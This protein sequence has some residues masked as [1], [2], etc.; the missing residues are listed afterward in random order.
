MRLW[1]A[2]RAVSGVIGWL[3]FVWATCGAIGVYGRVAISW[4]LALQLVLAFVVAPL[5]VLGAPVELARRALRPRTDGTLGPR[6]LV[7]GI[8]DSGTMRALTQPWVATVL[9]IGGFVGFH[10]SGLLDLA[11][12]THPGHLVM[13]VLTLAVGVLWST[14]IIGS[15]R[16][17]EA[18]SAT[19][20]TRS[21]GDRAAVS[22]RGSRAALGCL[23]VVVVA[24]FAAAYWLSRTTS[25]LAGDLFAQMALGW[26]HDLA[27]DQARAGAVALVAVPVCVV[28]A[29]VLATVA[30]RAGDNGDD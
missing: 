24:A 9:L 1:P 5:I 23:I 26:D 7:L 10:A 15:A 17:S 12:T 30:R 14:A 8:A 28:L 29:A 18:V 6:E 16:R 20:R 22:R 19:D 21:G 3:V 2:W 11:L 25:L 4:H 13:V 27:T